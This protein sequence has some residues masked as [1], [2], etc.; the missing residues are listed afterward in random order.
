MNNLFKLNSFLDNGMRLDAT[1]DGC[2]YRI[3]L[4]NCTDYEQ[5]I[6]DITLF[7]A[8]MIFSPDTRFYGEGFNML[9]QYGGTIKDFKLI[10]SFSDYTH[11][12]L[13]KPEGCNQ[14][15]NMLILYPE[16]QKP[17]LIGF[18]SCFRFNGWIRFNEEY[19]KIALNGENK[20]VKAGKT[21]RLEDVYIEQG[22][23]DVIIDNFASAIGKN[24]PKREFEK[25]P[26]GW[27]SW[28]V[29]GPNITAKN[30][31]DNLDAIKENGLDLEYIQ[32]DDG[33][34]AHWGDWF[35]FTDKFENGVKSICLDI[36]EKG[37]EPAI[38]VAP[39]VAEK[40]S[41]VFKNH[42]DW[43]VKDDNG[44]PLSSGDVSFGG[45]RCAPWYILDTTHPEAL[46]Y[47]K[48]VFHTM[49]YEWQIKYF[50][51]DAIV[52]ETLPFGH[53]Y[54]D[55]KTSVEAFRLGMD[56]I[57][58]ASGK[59]SFI[60][61]GNSPM[62]PSIGEV[63]GMRVTNDNCRVWNQFK[64]L[65]KECFPRNWQ[66]LRLWINDPDTVLLQNEKI[67]VVGP[68]GKEIYTLGSIS[69][70]EFAFN[71][72]YT[73]ASGGM[74]LSGDDV[75]NLTKENIELLRRLLPPSRIAASF[76]YENYT[77]GRAR[78]D[79]NKEYVYIF[80]FE[81]ESKDICVPLDGKTEVYDLIDNV[82]LG[83]YD[84]EITFPSFKAHNAKV[85]TCTKK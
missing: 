24:H 46:N 29:Y 63:H 10:G 27:C 56:A 35:E 5:E 80:N 32:I 69:K 72:A 77:V 18:A 9:S 76:E 12:K 13:Y 82:E 42:P 54:D 75:S 65:A 50:K 16:G 28:L 1:Q 78:V 7:T 59:D 21:V 67:K 45:W 84:G 70:E 40:D 60:L 25:I 71:A 36:K 38:W 30:I 2:L 6:G 83:T 26:T 47:I 34:Q 58:E 4:T 73:V 44:A 61:G 49:R 43:F 31:Y 64:Q 48:T 53:R 19:I 17:L 55:T 85:L 33:Y 68:D 20:K 52:W 66:H 22:D 11:Y 74:V 14:V 62:W 57:Y 23:I 15:Y 79:E 51:L 41:K 3:T 8:D 37:F 39:F 81:D